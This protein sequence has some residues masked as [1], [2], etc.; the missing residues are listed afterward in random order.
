MQRSHRCRRH[1]GCLPSLPTSCVFLIVMLM[2]CGQQ[3]S[4]VLTEQ[5][6]SQAFSEAEKGKSSLHVGCWGCVNPLPPCGSEFTDTDLMCLTFRMVTSQSS[7]KV[8][9]LEW[10]R[11]CQGDW[12]SLG[13]DQLCNLYERTLMEWPTD[14]E[15]HQSR[16]TLRER[17]V[18]TTYCQTAVYAIKLFPVLQLTQLWDPP[19][20]R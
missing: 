20:I 14:T 4:N 6:P 15:I 10:A 9:S 12:G 17:C 19:L 3:S 5:F 1:A 18:K 11:K 2:L 13:W 7:C 16:R 8:S